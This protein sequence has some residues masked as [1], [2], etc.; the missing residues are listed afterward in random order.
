M[1]LRAQPAA[2]DDP[3]GEALVRQPELHDALVEL[4]T[5]FPNHLGVYA[6]VV[7]PGVVGVG[8]TAS[9]R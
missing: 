1:P 5:T 6:E 7:T 9:V 3:A 2:A 4:N 8:D